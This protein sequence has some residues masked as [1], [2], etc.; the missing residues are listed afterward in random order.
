MADKKTKPQGK[1][2]L[3]V[4]EL[5]TELRL[6]LDKNVKLLFQHQ[7]TPLKSPVELRVLR[8]EIARL[9]TFIRQKEAVK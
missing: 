6:A 8:R 4:A 2:T 5:K 3:S 1:G 7:V 9:K